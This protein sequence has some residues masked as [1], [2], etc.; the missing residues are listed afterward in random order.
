M[1]NTF[2]NPVA[3]PGMWG[4]PSAPV[5]V[6]TTGAPP[7]TTSDLGVAATANAVATRP[8]AVA[9][10]RM[11]PDIL[12]AMALAANHAGRSAG[13]VWAEAARE[14]LLRKSLDADYDVLAHMPAKKRPEDA[15]LDQQR[16]RLWTSIESALEV[17]RQPQALME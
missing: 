11:A 14:W 9:W 6:T 1:A 12:R 17:I 4:E 16:K 13:E 2:L 7:A 5:Q 3:V 15:A 10:V 8:K